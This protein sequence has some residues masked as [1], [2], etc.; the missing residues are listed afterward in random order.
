M[1]LHHDIMS[2]MTTCAVDAFGSGDALPLGSSCWVPESGELCPPPPQQP[3]LWAGE[4]DLP[5]QVLAVADL[6]DMALPI[7]KAY[8]RQWFLQSHK[9]MLQRFVTTS[10]GG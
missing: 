5:A 8:Q 7:A 4:T 2:H 9:V 10:E 6:A 3:G 1:I